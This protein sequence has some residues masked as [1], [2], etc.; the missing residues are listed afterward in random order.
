MFTYSIHV[1]KQIK[2]AKKINAKILV[3]DLDHLIRSYSSR[4]IRIFLY[5]SGYPF[6]HV[7]YVEQTRL[8][9]CIVIN[10]TLALS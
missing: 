1:Y 4:Y 10:K 2:T 9:N 7:P 8:D 6:T 5:V 3:L